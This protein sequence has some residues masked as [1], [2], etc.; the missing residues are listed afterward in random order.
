[1]KFQTFLFYI[2]LFVTVSIVAQKRPNVILIMADD[3]GYSDIGCYGGEIKT[4]NLDMLANNGVRFSQFYNNARCCPTRAS[5]L[6][7]LYPHQAG[8]GGM[9]GNGHGDLSQNA[10]TIAEVLKLNG[11]ATYMTGKW[12]VSD[13]K[14]KEDMHNWPNQRGFDNFFGTITGAGSYFEPHTLT[15]NNKEVQLKPSDNFYYTDAISDSTVSFLNVHY[16]EKKNTPFFFYVAY[17]APHWPL[18]A[19]EKDIKKYKGTFDKGWDVLRKERLD[20]MK[21]I[22]VV[23]KNTKLSPRNANAKAWTQIENKNWE[24]QRMMTYAA[25]ID[26]MD[27]GIGR[28]IKNLKQ[29]DEL[30]NTLIFFLSDNGGCDEQLKGVEKWVNAK[31]VTQTISGKKV[32]KGNIPG[33]MSGPAS[34]YMSYG[35]AW[36]NLSNTPYRKY[37]KSG[38]QGGVAT[39]FIMHWPEGIKNKNSIKTEVASIIDIM[40]TILEA[41]QGNYPK[42]FNNNTIQPMEGLSLL[43]V[44]KNN[45]LDR[46]EWFVEHGSNKAF[47]KGDWKIAWSRDKNGKKW[48]LFNLKDDPTELNDLASKKPER[49]SEMKSRW[50][51]WAKRVKVIKKKKHK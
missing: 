48:E 28:I 1:M 18:H 50:Y 40:P 22:G 30:E 6:T 12:H 31:E 35:G 13:S 19:L 24:L 41:T 49:L 47:R 26:N 3:M 15:R 7:G 46:D 32:S 10:V 42:T 38:H 33:V 9:V 16:K 37:K 17:T 2:L 39:P 36:A 4:P 20:R 44:C 8:V 27:Q 25:Q 45:R 43:P 23:P 29:N 14:S 34:T 11:Y 51:E 5:I 21:K